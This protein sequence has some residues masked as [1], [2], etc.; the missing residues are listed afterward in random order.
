MQAG[1][2]N[3][4]RFWRSAQPRFQ[5]VDEVKVGKVRESSRDFIV[6]RSVGAGGRV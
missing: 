4:K 2:G 6:A 3:V 5:D 1:W